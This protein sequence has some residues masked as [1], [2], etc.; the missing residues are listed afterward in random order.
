MQRQLMQIIPHRP[1]SD[2]AGVKIKRTLGQT[3]RTRLDPFLMLDEFK[4][5]SA[6]DYIGGF[7]AHPHRGFET[8]TYMLA[9]HMLHEDHMGNRGDL[10]G[11]DVQWMTAGRGI[12]HSEMPQQDNGLMH[13]FQLWINLPADEKMKPA[14]YRDI[15]AEDIPFVKLSDGGSIKVIAGEVSAE[16]TTVSGPIQG[17]STQPRYWDLRLPP[18]GTFSQPL[19][20]GHN[21]F[22]YVF[23]GDVAV[24]ADNRR[25]ESG[26]AGVLGDGTELSLT[27]GP[28]GVSVLILSGRPIGEPIAQYGPFVMNTS[29]EI[30]EAIEAYRQGRLA[31]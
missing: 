26:N 19:P 6:D 17:L 15:P 28:K 29:E 8:V 22:L 13:G 21:V 11:G 4:S 10:K 9:G 5:D 20:Q 30:E 25:L 3:Q 16:G 1:T 24:G 2:G 12:I 14:E 18:N 31:S 27:A 7:P 23:E